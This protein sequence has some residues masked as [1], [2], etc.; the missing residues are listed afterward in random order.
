MTKKK[1]ENVT[2]EGSL[3]SIQFTRA[4]WNNFQ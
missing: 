4:P 2:R 1:E 3:R